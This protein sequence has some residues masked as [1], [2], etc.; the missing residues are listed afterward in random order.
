MTLSHSNQIKSFIFPSEVG[1]FVRNSKINWDN[2]KTR[3][4][5]RENMK[6]RWKKTGKSKIEDNGVYGDTKRLKK[7]K[8]FCI[9]FLLFLSFLFLFHF[10]IQT[11]Y[12][13]KPRWLWTCFRLNRFAC[14]DATLNRELESRIQID[15]IM[16]SGWRYVSRLSP[17]VLYHIIRFSTN[18]PKTKTFPWQ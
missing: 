16:V 18:M 15:L 6:W 3:N 1:L 12:K 13:V 4:T 5:V 17:H 8:N 14:F 11:I 10:F 2:Q 9:F 7:P